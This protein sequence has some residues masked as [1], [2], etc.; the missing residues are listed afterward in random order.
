MDV[1]SC[2][3]ST[4]CLNPI[5][6]SLLSAYK[7]EYAKIKIKFTISKLLLHLR[8]IDITYFIDISDRFSIIDIRYFSDI[9]D[10]ADS[11]DIN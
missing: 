4:S 8:E 1:T 3:K 5:Y 10:F 6:H 7:L 11:T 2:D 9:T